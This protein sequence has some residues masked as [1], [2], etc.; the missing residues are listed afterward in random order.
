MSS[1]ALIVLAALFLASLA[2]YVTCD[3]PD[4]EEPQASPETDGLIYAIEPVEIPM[5]LTSFGT[6]RSSSENG[7]PCGRY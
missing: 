3:K 1:D 5:S 2:T 6:L 4:G 7:M